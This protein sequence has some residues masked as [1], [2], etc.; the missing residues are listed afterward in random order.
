MSLQ[1][2]FLI[3]LHVTSIFCNYLEVESSYKNPRLERNNIVN[4]G[5]WVRNFK[6]NDK[7]AGGNFLFRGNSIDVDNI[8]HGDFNAFSDNSGPN[9]PFISSYVERSKRSAD[10]TPNQKPSERNSIK[11]E[12]RTPITSIINR[13]LSHVPDKRVRRYRK[14]LTK[15]ENKNCNTNNVLDE[16]P[17]LIKSKLISKLKPAS[18]FNDYPYEIAILLGNNKDAMDETKNYST[19]VINEMIREDGQNLTVIPLTELSN[20]TS[21]LEA[22]AEETN[23]TNSTNVVPKRSMNNYESEVIKKIE[24][25]EDLNKTQ[26]TTRS[27]IDRDMFAKKDEAWHQNAPVPDTHKY[28]VVNKN[29]DSK[30]IRP[31]TERGLIKVLSMLTNTFKKI[32]KQH[33]DIKEIHKKLH[34]M[35]EDFLKNVELI[36]DKF[37]D[38]ESKYANLVAFNQKITEMDEKLTAREQHFKTKERELSKNLVEF[39]IQQKKFLTQQRQFY[40]IQKLMLA[41]NER[42]NSKQNAIAKTQ[43]EISHR[44]NNFARI[45]KKAKQVYFDSKHNQPKTSPSASPPYAKLDNSATA[46]AED[47]QTPPRP[48]TLRPVPTDSVK[49]NLFSI[50]SIPRIE[51]QDHLLLNEKDE[52]PVDDLVYKYYFNNTFID[53]LMKNFLTGFIST[54]ELNDNTRNYK[55]K[56]DEVTEGTTL[57]LPVNNPGFDELGGKVITRER[58]WISHHSRKKN[59]RKNRGKGAA[60]NNNADDEKPIKNKKAVDNMFDPTP[61]K[62]PNEMKINTIDLHKSDAFITMATGFCKGIGQSS[63]PQILDW[64]V[65]KALRRLQNIEIKMPP[66]PPPTEPKRDEKIYVPRRKPSSHKETTVSTVVPTIENHPTTKTYQSTLSGASST[67]VLYTYSPMS[68]VLTETTQKLNLF[69]PDNEKIESNLKQFDLRPDTEGNFYYDGSLHAS[70]VIKDDHNSESDI[71]PGLDSNSRIDTID[72]ENFDTQAMRRAMLR[73]SFYSRMKY[74]SMLKKMTKL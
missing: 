34:G 5:V 33:S 26:G 59:R 22:I 50:P 17:S 21:K 61:A 29:D 47:I 24:I 73:R 51:N 28:K 60:E 13:F 40:N 68:T 36:S 35:N 66:L 27:F 43:S 72:P 1:Q 49:I 37:Q 16:N 20:V 57:L 46:K 30:I 56:R 52:Q 48:S 44:Q 54:G 71:M 4:K 58:R 2:A 39:E 10:L 70:D 42:I 9:S 41:Q 31:V 38:F 74:E 18:V 25:A 8:I 14:S 12:T 7:L 67:P 15:C 63:S 69:F 53:T 19:Y 32:M 55:S 45:L 62:T 65:E 3:T 64:C 11:K 6:E 23:K